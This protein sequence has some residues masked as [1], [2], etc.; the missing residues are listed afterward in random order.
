MMDVLHH[1]PY[2]Q[3]HAVLASQYVHA[4]RYRAERRAS[5]ACAA[6]DCWPWHTPEHR[7]NRPYES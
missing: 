3:T 4:L 1:E 5:T 7:Q 2:D 6:V